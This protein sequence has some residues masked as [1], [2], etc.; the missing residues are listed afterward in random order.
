MRQNKGGPTPLRTPVT[1]FCFDPLWPIP[2][3]PPSRP[4]AAGRSRL[5]HFGWSTAVSSRGLASCG[6]PSPATLDGIRTGQPRS[7]H[8]RSSARTVTS[9]PRGCSSSTESVRRSSVWRPCTGQRT[10]RRCAEAEEPPSR[11]GVSVTDLP[12]Q[13]PGEAG[14]HDPSAFPTA[15]TRD[16]IHGHLATRSTR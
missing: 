12:P 13:V 9:I 8:V 1:F 5:G 3:A 6:R 14:P 7:S 4:G 11:G 2:I 10:E 16:I 15:R